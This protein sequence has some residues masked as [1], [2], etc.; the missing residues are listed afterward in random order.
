M[1]S[2]EIDEM[3]RVLGNA[4][5]AEW[6]RKPDSEF[7]QSELKSVANADH[8]S[9]AMQTLQ[10][11][12]DAMSGACRIVQNMFAEARHNGLLG[13]DSGSIPSLMA[14]ALKYGT[15]FED[16]TCQTMSDILFEPDF[17]KVSVSHIKNQLGK[18]SP[19][20]ATLLQKTNELTL[21]FQKH[22]ASLADA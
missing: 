16:G 8:D 10:E 19:Q 7:S 5:W 14:A 13:E 17:K 4:A 22:K 9:E 1:N 3:L 15:Q 12:F 2:Q 21:L 6:G 20:M 11:G 18:A